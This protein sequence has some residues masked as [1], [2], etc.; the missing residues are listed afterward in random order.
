MVLI[1]SLLF[2]DVWMEVLLLMWGGRCINI[3]IL[4]DGLG[5]AS[6]AVWLLARLLEAL[7]THGFDCFVAVFCCL[8]GGLDMEVL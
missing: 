5:A 1:G 6:A 4:G 3:F 2:S 7:E 8:D